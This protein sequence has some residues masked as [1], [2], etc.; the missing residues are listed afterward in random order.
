M[1]VYD[2]HL[3]HFPSPVITEDGARGTRTLIFV[4][5]SGSPLISTEPPRDSARSLIPNKP[6]EFGSA[7]CWA[8][9]PFPL[10]LIVKQ[11]VDLL[12][13]S[14]NLTRLAC[15]CLAMLFSPSWRIRKS[16]VEI[17][18]LRDNLR[19]AILNSH[20]IPVR[21]ANSLVCHS[22]AALNPNL[23]RTPGLSSVDKLLTAEIVSPRRLFISVS[24]SLASR[25]AV[26][27]SALRAFC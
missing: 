7:I 22:I 8:V 23:S 4:P 15:E 25:I 3:N 2:Q 12:I 17:S 11:T 21:L 10:S 27:G 5:R 13:L 20:S 24:F 14:D 6:S 26:V 18:L 1:V 9:I 16:A 19:R